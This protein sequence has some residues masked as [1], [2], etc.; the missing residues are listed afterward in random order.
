MPKGYKSPNK[1]IK[2]FGIVGDKIV[3]KK[4]T[5]YKSSKKLSKNQKLEKQKLINAVKSRVNRGWPTGAV[6]F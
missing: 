5:T 4:S 3:T 1:P 2:P 6:K